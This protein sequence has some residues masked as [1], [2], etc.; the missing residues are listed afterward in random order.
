M[1]HLTFKLPMKKILTITLFLF[2]FSLQAQ[3]NFRFADTT[4]HW[5]ILE[6]SWGGPFPPFVHYYTYI[7]KETGDTAINGVMY[8]KINGGT[9]N[10][11]RRDSLNRIYT[12]VNNEELKLYDF[13]ALAGDSI[14]GLRMMW[15]YDSIGCKVASAD[16]VN[17]NGLK[18]RMIVNC[19]S[20]QGQQYTDTWIDGVGSLYNHAFRGGS[21]Q[22]YV[23]APEY[24]LLCYFEG[25]Q[26]QYQNPA[27]SVC[28]Y[29]NEIE[30]TSTDEVAIFPNPAA[31]QLTLEWRTN[32]LQAYS[33][34]TAD[35]KAVCR[36]DLESTANKAVVDCS[37]LAAGVYVLQLQAK[38]GAYY[39]RIVIE[40]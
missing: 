32:D 35:G 37:D 7:F 14:T 4:G 6:T 34:C 1:I 11:L 36:V 5:D 38:H 12:L 40:H 24:E 2:Q 29:Y 28:L 26:Q 10:Y 3:T 25:Y 13:G 19:N 17:W 27:Y 8:Q 18:K 39:H 21:E 15:Y 31:N 9:D 33:I 22:L 30:E 16:T 20:G 23:D